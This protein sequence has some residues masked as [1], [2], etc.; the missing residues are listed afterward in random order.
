METLCSGISAEDVKWQRAKS[1]R[2]H[3]RKYLPP[4][5]P[6]PTV[7]RSRQG[8]S[9]LPELSGLRQCLLQ[10]Y[11]QDRFWCWGCKLNNGLISTAL[12][13]AASGVVT[14]GLAAR[15][16]VCRPSF[17]IKSF[18]L[19]VSALCSVPPRICVALSYCQGFTISF[20]HRFQF[21][22]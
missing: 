1:K 12:F 18:A 9:K 14:V 21:E 15:R 6:L 4:L 22:M 7:W 3:F 13:S 5:P 8:R 17:S 10:L 19:E 11:N 20:T 2:A 16:I